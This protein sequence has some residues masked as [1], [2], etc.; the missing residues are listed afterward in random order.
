MFRAGFFY[1]KLVNPAAGPTLAGSLKK[2]IFPG[3]INKRTASFSGNTTTGTRTFTTFPA[4]NDGL[5]RK[6][7]RTQVVSKYLGPL[8]QKR[9]ATHSQ[10]G[11]NGYSY[12]EP[13]YNNVQ[14]N[15]IKPFIFVTIFTVATYFAIPFLFEHTPM[16]YFKTHP[17]HLVWTILGLNAI[18]FGLWQIRFSNAYL[19]KTLENYF[20]M[21]RSALT[22]TSNWSL[23]LSSFSHQE[24]FHLLVNMGCL[25]SFSGTMI[26]MLGI[27]GFSS[28]YLISGA[29]ASFFS[30]AYSQI[31]RYFG[32]SLGASGSIAG[33]FTTFATMFPNA[34]IS[35]FFIP[36]PGGAAVAAGLFAL[37]NV[38]GCLLKWGSFDYAAHLGGMWVGFL[39]GI[40]LKWKLEKQEEER[41]KKLRSYGWR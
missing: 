30:L 15:I 27:T 8:T 21:D 34:G 11:R 23:I 14:N 37:Y 26:S 6:I 32:R 13:R 20:V 39:W 41:R 35:F 31:F 16:S 1:L 29:W 22:R 2:S 40:F 5:T 25:Y 7:L 9:L 19:Y 3:F 10:L 17:T 4:H 18:V 33:V 28:L 36:V 24:P 12:R 38:A